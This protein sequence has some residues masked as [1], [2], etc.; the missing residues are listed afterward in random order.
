MR[1]VVTPDPSGLGN[2][3]PEAKVTGFMPSDSQA[4]KTVPEARQEPFVLR[5]KENDSGAFMALAL[6]RSLPIQR[7]ERAATRFLVSLRHDMAL[8]AVESACLF[9]NIEFHHC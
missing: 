6:P 9:G 8:G 7:R 3:A 4:T 1:Q 5:T 2:G